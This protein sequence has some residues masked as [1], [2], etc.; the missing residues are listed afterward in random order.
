MNA[1]IISTY[2]LL[3][4]SSNTHPPLLMC[5]KKKKN[6]LIII[7]TT[8]TSHAGMQILARIITIMVS[9]MQ[10]ENVMSK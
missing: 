1:F 9:R 2:I 7:M 3:F 5:E 6:A 10:M 8:T 4:G